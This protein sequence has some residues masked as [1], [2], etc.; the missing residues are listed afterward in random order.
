ME[1][2]NS[3][4]LKQVLTTIQVPINQNLNDPNLL[5]STSRIL[6]QTLLPQPVVPLNPNI[7]C[8]RFKILNF[9]WDIT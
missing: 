2:V 9:K 6:Q 3:M 8:S 1:G 7:H 4:V 5:Y